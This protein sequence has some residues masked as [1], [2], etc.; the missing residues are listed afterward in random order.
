M[1]EKSTI[2]RILNE[3]TPVWSRLAP[4]HAARWL[5]QR[6][7]TPTRRPRP[8]REQ[9]WIAG[10]IRDRVRFRPGVELPIYDWG[11]DFGGALG[12]PRPPTVLLVHG[13]AGR[14]SQ[15]GAFVEPLLDRGFRVVS[16]DAPGHGEAG[17]ARSALPELARAIERVVEHLGS[18][19]AMICHSMG[20]AAATVALARGLS[21][22]RLIYLAPPDPPGEYLHRV[23]DHLG[24]SPAVAR[25]A[26]ARIESRYRLSFDAIHGSK[27][28]PGLDTSLLVIHDEL[29]R[30]VPVHEG[31]R[32][33]AAWPH[34]KTKTTRGLGHTR[35]LRAPEVVEAAVA[36]LA[37]LAPHAKR[38]P[39]LSLSGG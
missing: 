26:Q 24:F 29:D 20:A 28:A 36:F 17:G 22:E 8:A 9:R 35:M 13:W 6:F 21:V 39:R 19:D 2:V 33:A 7:T 10:A 5:A 27:L 15:L 34:A 12:D 3:V 38:H 11:W 25:M 18:V 1:K 14:G 23:A 37:S 32:L 31:L 30:E 4:A 16:F